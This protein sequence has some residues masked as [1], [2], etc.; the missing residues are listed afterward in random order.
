[1]TLKDHK[2]MK[3]KFEEY[4]EKI[5]KVSALEELCLLDGEVP[6]ELTETN[7]Q[8]CELLPRLLDRINAFWDNQERMLLH[9][10]SLYV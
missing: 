1:M 6:I 7:R 2:A 3:R 9:I 10:N 8:Y 5:K 4:D